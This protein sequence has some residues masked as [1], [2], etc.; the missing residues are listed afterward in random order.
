MEWVL[1]SVCLALGCSA[2]NASRVGTSFSSRHCCRTWSCRS[3]SFPTSSRSPGSSTTP[4]S[5][6]SFLAARRAC[7]PPA[8]RGALARP[9]PHARLA[10]RVLRC[11]YE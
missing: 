10:G 6:L 3:T 11:L 8:R 7:Q 4:W 1:Y 9:A 5:S 2:T